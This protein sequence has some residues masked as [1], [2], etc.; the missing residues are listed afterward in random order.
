MV[1]MSSNNEKIISDAKNKIKALNSE[2]EKVNRD[3]N[4]LQIQLD[5]SMQNFNDL[6]ETYDSLYKRLPSKQE[7]DL[8][9]KLKS[10]KAFKNQ[11]ITLKFDN[12]MNFTLGDKLDDS[13]KSNSRTESKNNDVNKRYLNKFQQ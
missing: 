11:S 6:Q 8:I 9:E 2:M 5:M 10:F 12:K 3:Y 7:Q 4:D 1:N 13:N